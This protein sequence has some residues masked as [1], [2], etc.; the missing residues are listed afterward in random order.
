MSERSEYAPGEFCWVDL[1]TSDTDAAAKLYGELLGWET[2][3]AGPVEETG[4]YGFFLRDGKQVAGYGPLQAEGQPPAWSS[5]VK[6]ADADETRGEGQAGRRQRLHGAVRSARRLGADGRDRRP[7]RRRPVR[8]AAKA[9]PR[10]PARQ[11]G[12]LLDLEPARDPRPRRRQGLLRQGLRLGPGAV[13]G[14]STRVAVLDVAGRRTEVGGG[15]RRSDGDGSRDPAGHPAPLDGLLR[16]RERRRR[17]RDREATRRNAALRPPGHPGRPARGLHRS[18]GRGLRGDSAG[19]SRSRSLAMEQ[20]AAVPASSR[21][22]HPGPPTRP[23]PARA[24]AGAPVRARSD[25][26]L[27]SPSPPLRQRLLPVVPLLRPDRLRGRPGDRQAGLHRRLRPVPRGRGQRDGARADARPELG[28]DARRGRASAPAKA[29]AAAFSRGEREPVR[30]ADS[31]DHGA[32]HEELADWRAICPA[33]AH[34]ADH[35]GGDP[36]GGVRH[37]RRGALQARLDAG[38]RVRPQGRPDHAAPV[39]ATRPRPLQPLVAL[40]A[41]PALPWTS[42]STRR[43]PRGAR[44]RAARSTTTC[45]RCCC[46][47]STTTAAR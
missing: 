46:P 33:P 3:S 45:S 43:S 30:R 31:P 34:A 8:H 47:P 13:R 28:A 12:R 24:R 40:P 20:H 11:R 22:R 17:H 1:A 10:R 23:T 27:H 32:R 9:A 38:R 39:A 36:E 6:V 15:D 41:T 37:P 44:R 25:R 21:L 7:E 2:Q 18:A 16:R 4:G 35:A 5:Y 14:G 29:S 26:L 19:L 42:S